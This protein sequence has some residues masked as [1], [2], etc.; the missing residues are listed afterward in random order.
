[1]K[2]K[3]YVYIM[4]FFAVVYIA[5]ITF[6]PFYNPIYFY[7][8]HV[9]LFLFVAMF[10]FFLMKFGYNRFN[11]KVTKKNVL[12]IFTVV[13][14]GILLFGFS[15]IQLAFIERYQTSEFQN[16]AYYDK[17]DNAI[18]Y[19]QLMNQCPDLEIITETDDTLIFS[20]YE[21]ADDLAEPGYMTSNI[22]QNSKMKAK[23]RVDVEIHYF[24]GGTIESV[25]TFKSTNIEI[26]NDEEVV[27]AFNSFHTMIV[28]IKELDENGNVV[29]YQSNMTLDVLTD[30]IY[31]YTD[32]EEVNHYNGDDFET[33]FHGYKSTRTSYSSYNSV[34]QIVVKEIDYDDESFTTGE[35][36][37]ISLFD[38]VCFEDNCSIQEGRSTGTI[39]SND[40]LEYYNDVDT[41]ITYYPDTGV[42]YDYETYHYTES[43]NARVQTTYNEFENHD[44][45]FSHETT[46]YENIFNPEIN[47]ETFKYL[48]R[49]YLTH[50]RFYSIFEDTEYGTKVITKF[51]ELTDD[52]DYYRNYLSDFVSSEYQGIQDVGRFRTF[53]NAHLIN[54]YGSR[55]DTI[56]SATSFE[57]LFQQ[58][59]LLFE[60]I[61]M[62]E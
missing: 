32:F 3:L 5:S 49:T 48:G 2:N 53:H 28:N 9:S 41:Y 31:D 23:T 42:I 27:K 26:T 25:E 51:S 59:P 36:K 24:D 60:L 34:F 39:N 11:K 15:N 50:G 46:T 57:I 16:C 14:F 38:S 37:I 6:L 18:Y 54:D 20:V 56:N 35:A 45:V 8:Q 43:E 55:L 44:M 29:T 33:Y 17:Y 58:N 10:I 30:R 62:D 13:M 7:I 52:D 4:V 12:N 21:E 19:T 40:P 22:I 1:M 47:R 61:V